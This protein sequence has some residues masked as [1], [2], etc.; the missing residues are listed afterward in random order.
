M[1]VAFQSISSDPCYNYRPL[2]RPWIAN[3]E[4]GDFIC[5]ETLVWNGWYRLFYYGMD[6]R[7][8][9]T[10]VSS[11][12][13]NTGVSLS[14]NGPH[15]QDGVVTREVCG[16]ACGEAYLRG[17]WNYKSKPVRV[18]ACP[19]NYY[20][21]ELVNPLFGCSGYCTDV[22]TISQ[23]VSTVGPDIFTG[24]SITLNDDPCN[25]YNILNDYSRNTHHS[26]FV[27]GFGSVLDDTLEEWDGWYRLFMNDLSAQMPEWCFYYMSCGGFSALWLGGSHPRLEDGVVTREIYGSYR[28]QC[29]HYRSDPIQ[30][31][32]CPGNYYVYK[33]TRPM[34]LIPAPRYC[35][36][37]FSTPSVDPCYNYT[38]L[39]EPWRATDHYNLGMCDYNVEWNG[40]YRLFYNGQNAQ[41]PESCVNQYMCGTDQPLWLNG[42]HP[43]LEDGEVTRQICVSSWNGCCTY[44]S[45]PIRVKDCPGNYYVYEFVKP[46]FCSSYCVDVTGLNATSATTET[47]PAIETITMPITTTDVRDH[48]SEL[49][50]S[51]DERC[52]ERNGFYG[53]LCN[54]EQPRLQPDSFDSSETCESRFSMIPAAKERSGMAEWNSILIMMN[55]SVVQILCYYKVLPYY[56]NGTHFIYD[57]FILGT[58]RSEGLI[59]SRQKILKLSFSC[60][61]P[62]TQ[63][64]SMNVEINP[65]ESIVHKTLPA[66]E[67]RYRVRMIP[68]QDDEFT[69]PFTGAVDAELDQEMHVEVRVEG[70]DSR[71][72]ALVMDTC[73]ATPVNDPDYSLRW[74]LIDSECPNPNDNTVEL[75]QNG[76]SFRMFIFTANSTKLYLHCAVHLCLL[77]SNRCSMDCDSGHQ[78]RER[79]SLDF[80]DSA[81]I[82]MGPLM[83]SEGNTDKLVPDQV[84]VSEASCLCGSLLVFLVPL[85]SVLT[86][87]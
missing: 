66:G 49:S 47:I 54:A 26:W 84:K 39:D 34:V 18:K 65:L 41:M 2:D 73:W 17:C 23:L 19:G 79:R 36:V 58:P 71:Q 75:L 22:S 1:T 32:A 38:S 3:N 72:F 5:D 29:S 51:E 43:Q 77:S 63:T 80:H 70:V 11:S 10:C 61:Y 83:L 85:M 4:S 21:Y 56:A 24:S 60:V 62:Q 40:W 55:T 82:S 12:Y 44:T 27:F 76:V 87:F 33:F 74:D 37:S 15:P 64:L 35:A 13:C 48:C 8:P 14:L 9:E 67:G 20:V 68:Y 30:V 16:E 78:R 45:H 31:K 52:G 57:N 59:I 46:P 50:C 7:M 42:P 6:I 86:H 69:R 28:D 25:N 81:S 53:C